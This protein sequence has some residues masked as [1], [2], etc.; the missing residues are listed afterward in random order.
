MTFIIEQYF[1][2]IGT[3]FCIWHI[4]S[5][6]LQFAVISLHFSVVVFSC[7]VLYIFHQSYL[8]MYSLLFEANTIIIHV[9]LMAVLVF[10]PVMLCLNFTRH[11]SV[12]P[13]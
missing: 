11:I 9:L 13:E 3:V 10:S 8:P 6:L 12:I 2:N 7:N 5:L 4:E 1:I